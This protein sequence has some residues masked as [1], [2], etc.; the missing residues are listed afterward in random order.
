MRLEVINDLIQEYEEQRKKGIESKDLSNLIKIL[1][2][3][4]QNNNDDIQKIIDS[5]KK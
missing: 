4:K 5:L 1:E 3:T 2:T